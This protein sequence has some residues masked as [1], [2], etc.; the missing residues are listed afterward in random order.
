MV[1]I[2]AVSFSYQMILFIKTQGSQISPKIGRVIGFG[3]L[4]VL[5]ILAFGVVKVTFEIFNF[6]TK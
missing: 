2:K 1:D 4:F 3:V 6:F 5:I